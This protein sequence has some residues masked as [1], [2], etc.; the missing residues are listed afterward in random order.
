M[1]RFNIKKIKA[2]LSVVLFIFI[3]IFGL[4]IIFYFV[5]I[6]YFSPHGFFKQ[7]VEL[8]QIKK[9]LLLSFFTLF[10]II[11]R[12]LYN[13]I[14][15]QNDEYINIFELLHNAFK[16]KEFWKALLVSPII[17]IGFYKTIDSINSNSLISLMAFENGFFFNSVIETRK[18]EKYK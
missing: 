5:D 9:P 15:I 6:Y 12:I 14:E 11:S 3:I 4:A 1:L 13:E 2:I 7:E 8:Y 10:G 18:K 16:S 17:L